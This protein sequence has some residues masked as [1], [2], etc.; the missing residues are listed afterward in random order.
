MRT[1]VPNF[2]AELLECGVRVMSGCE[3]VEALVAA[4]IYIKR[5]GAAP[6]T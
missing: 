4:S 2:I 6:Y 3:Y 1:A 5:F